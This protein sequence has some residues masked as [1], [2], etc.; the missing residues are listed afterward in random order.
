MT[1][2]YIGI[3]T[4]LAMVLS[5]CS[6]PKYAFQHENFDINGPF[7]HHFSASKQVAYESMKRVALRQGFSVEQKNNDECTMIVSKQYQEDERNT[8][9]TISGLVTGGDT[10]ADAWIAAQEITLKS[11]TA[12]QTASIGL[13]LGLSLPIPTGKVA[14]LTKER[15]ETVLDKVF[16]DKIF[17]AIEKEIPLVQQQMK[18]TSAED[19]S[20]L[21]SDIEKKLR[22][23]MEIREKLEKEKLTAVSNAATKPDTGTPAV[24]APATPST[25]VK[26]DAQ[27]VATPT[28]TPEIK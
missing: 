10:Y 7:D 5:G 25:E 19:D 1:K 14:T 23:E 2:L 11:N 21:R 28:K 15:G 27:T 3:L 16:Y 18:T 4:T 6:G 17:T 20:R 9:L 24:T 26:V 13:G 8:L 22:I 12:T